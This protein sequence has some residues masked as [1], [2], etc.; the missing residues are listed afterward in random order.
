MLVF[1]YSIRHDKVMFNS[2]RLNLCLCFCFGLN[3]TRAKRT[4]WPWLNST[5][6]IAMSQ[7]A[8]NEAASASSASVRFHA[9]FP[10][11]L[12]VVPYLW[13]S[14]SCKIARVSIKDATPPLYTCRLAHRIFNFIGYAVRISLKPY[15]PGQKPVHLEYS[16]FA[17]I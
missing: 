2:L 5:R 4:V 6:D 10:S 1:F 3:P 16:I 9:K 7:P 14:S 17:H 15:V 8:A 13:V 11:K 12:A